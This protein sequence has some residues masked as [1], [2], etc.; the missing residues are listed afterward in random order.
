[1]RKAQTEQ[2]ETHHVKHHET[3]MLNSCSEQKVPA[4]Q[5]VKENLELVLQ[6][7]HEEPRENCQL[8]PDTTEENIC[9]EKFINFYY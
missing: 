6:K 7:W 4:Q 2:H 1:M 5:K 9:K 3:Q 8:T